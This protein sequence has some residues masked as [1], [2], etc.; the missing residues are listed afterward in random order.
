MG[1]FGK[2]SVLFIVLVLLFTPLAFLL[3]PVIAVAAVVGAIVVL[4]GRRHGKHHGVS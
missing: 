3:L 1:S 2:E 4:F